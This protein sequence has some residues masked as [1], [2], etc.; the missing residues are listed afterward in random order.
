MTPITTK[1]LEEEL[2]AKLMVSF[3]KTPEEAT[4]GR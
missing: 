4:D 1:T 3:G 2:T